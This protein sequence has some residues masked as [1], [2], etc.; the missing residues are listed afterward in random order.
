[1][2]VLLLATYLTKSDLLMIRFHGY[3]EAISLQTLDRLFFIYLDVQPGY[4][5]G[6]NE[7]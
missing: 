5:P 6:A 4:F 3:V 1:M 2:K 7:V